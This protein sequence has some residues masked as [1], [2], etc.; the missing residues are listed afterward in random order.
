MLGGSRGAFDQCFS[1]PTEDDERL[2][3][4]SRCVPPDGLTRLQTNKT[5]AKPGGLWHPR[6]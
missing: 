5:A 2:F 3:N 4:L 1:F 6:Q